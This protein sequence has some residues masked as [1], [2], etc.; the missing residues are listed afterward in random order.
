MVSQ[1]E[2]SKHTVLMTVTV[3][4]LHFSCILKCSTPLLLVYDMIHSLRM[5]ECL[6]YQS[7]P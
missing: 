4:A 2:L 7:L 6:M 1:I 5:R 3:L